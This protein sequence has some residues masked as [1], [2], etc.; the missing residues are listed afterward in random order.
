MQQIIKPAYGF[1]SINIGSLTIYTGK[2]RIKASA[3]F[4]FNKLQ[5]HCQHLRIYDCKNNCATISFETVSIILNN[6][7]IDAINSTIAEIM[8]SR[9]DA[10]Y[11]PRVS[12]KIEVSD[13]EYFI[14]LPY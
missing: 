2:I 8:H 12:N 9:I 6:Q 4:L 13:Y 5:N 10:K 1:N 7:L 14:D 3:S 11:A